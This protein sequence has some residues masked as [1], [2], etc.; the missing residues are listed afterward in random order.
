MVHSNISAGSPLQKTVRVRP[1]FW[2]DRS[3]VLLHDNTPTHTTKK[4]AQF[5]AK[6]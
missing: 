2:K 1:E 3:F 5:L 6:K 4:N